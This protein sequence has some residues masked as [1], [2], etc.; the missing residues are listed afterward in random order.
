M[1]GGS[2][3]GCRA[4]A[5]FHF[6]LE[7]EGKLTFGGAESGSESLKVM[8]GGGGGKGGLFYKQKFLHQPT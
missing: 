7:G 5:R 1:H 8:G 3:A 2:G 4:S 6:S